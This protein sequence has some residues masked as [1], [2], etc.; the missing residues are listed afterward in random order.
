M[1]YCSL[2]LLSA[3]DGVHQ[4]DSS[5]VLTLYDFQKGEMNGSPVIVLAP[6]GKGSVVLS[7]SHFEF[8]EH[9]DS[10]VLKIIRGCKESRGRP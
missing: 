6:Y 2:D 7:S 3:F 8:T 4:S 5:N 1:S 10:L 9:Y